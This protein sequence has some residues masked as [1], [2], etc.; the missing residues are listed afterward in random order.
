[1][2]QTK[3]K[4]FHKNPVLELNQAIDSGSLYQ[5]RQMIKTLP[6]AGIAH[7]LESSPP[8]TRSVLW[9]LVDKDAEGEV[10]QYLNE[11]IQN[12]ILSSLNAEQVVKL[13]E[14]LETDDLAD[15]LQQLPQQVMAQV[16]R[17]MDQQDRLRVESIL[18]YD[19]DTAGG[20]MNTDTIAVRPRHTLDLV[21]RYLRRYD[22]IPEMTDNIHVVNRDDELLGLLPLRKV[23]VSDPNTTVREVMSSE[24]EAI[25]V[26]MEAT[27]VA[28]LFEQHD[29]VSAPVVDDEGKL[30]GRI[31]IDDVVDVIR[32]STEHSLMSMAGLDEEEDTFAPVI[33][34]A[35]RRAMWLGVN[36]MTAI[37]ASLVIY[38]FQDILDR[39]VYL[40]IL[41][42]IVANMGGVAGTQTLTLVIRSLALGHITP[43]N[44]RWLL[45]RE[46]GV[47]GLNGML[48]ALVISVIA[49]IWL[50]DLQISYIIGAAMMINMFIAAL[51]GAYLPLFLK[52]INVDP[53]LAGTVALT[54]VTDS[55]G[56]F[57][58]LG[59][60]QIFYL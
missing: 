9:Q 27:Q 60:A 7:L 17:A 31:T 42:P 5:V 11:D 4:H 1:M 50:D 40:A 30:L 13:T 46:L 18:S 41:M 20:L 29:W 47:A 25:P 33:K 16:L 24:I 8:K 32:D 12:D 54:T 44:S 23:L 49:Y 56:F 15:I 51:A 43:A 22:S 28:Q 34:T 35:R 45:A 57:S 55:I 58:F 36:L 19:E 26:A 6:T 37:L 48:W 21:L 39:V 10:L 14:G 3:E 53:A 38:L 2:P 52:R 59:L